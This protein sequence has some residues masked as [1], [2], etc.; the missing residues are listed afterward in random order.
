MSSTDSAARPGRRSP[1][2][3]GAGSS[4]DSAA[5]VAPATDDPTGT[6]A[7]APAATGQ[8]L[9]GLFIVLALI[10]SLLMVLR[11]D[12]SLAASLA[13][14]AAL[15]AAVIGAI[16]VTKYRRQAD[17]A[18]HRSRDLRLVYELQLERE[19]AAR[20][21]YESEV[22]AAIRNEVAEENNEEFEALKTQ[23]LA[24]RASLEK[25]LGNPLPEVP[26]A[27]RPERRRE[28][29]SGRS[30]AS[31]VPATDDRVA[32]SL[33]FETTAPPAEPG[34]HAPAPAGPAPVE[35]DVEL[36]DLIPVV[37]DEH[38]VDDGADEYAVEYDEVVEY[39]EVEYVEME[40][41]EPQYAEPQYAEPQYAEPQYAEPQYEAAQ[42]GPGYSAAS[43]DDYAP[44]TYPADAYVAQG[45]APPA[46]HPQGP[47]VP[48]VPPVP[49]MPQRSRRAQQQEDG[50]GAHTGGQPA[51]ELLSRL[52]EGNSDASGS[53]RRHRD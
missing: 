11:K 6:R 43:A 29:G 39:T 2:R 31:Y 32:A 33:D 22:E 5:K 25:L 21:Q 38:V 19:I 8:W 17:T 13:V 35:S 7:A 9:I 49:P 48:E 28:L 4:K 16:L 15:W 34:R 10:A 3:D 50:G 51:S 36:T 46:V 1:R 14:I 20:R 23:V 37:T 44:P 53:G 30:G 26:L 40:H 52:R 12:I 24:L 42:S 18:E 41:A 47:P 27:L 45:Y